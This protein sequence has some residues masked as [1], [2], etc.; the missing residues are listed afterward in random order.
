MRTTISR[1]W[2]LAAGLM[3]VLCGPILHA[4]ASREKPSPQPSKKARVLNVN[5]ASAAQ[6]QELPGIGVSTAARIVEY[7]QKHGPFKKVEDLMNIRGIGEKSFLRLKPLIT[8]TPGAPARQAKG[9]RL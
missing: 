2:L 4:Q 1:P 3:L 8:V 9:T 7:R 6:L 5:T